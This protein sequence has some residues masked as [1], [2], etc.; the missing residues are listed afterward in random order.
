[1]TVHRT[2]VANGHT[3]VELL[4]TQGTPIPIVNAFLRHLAAR[5][6]SPNTLI[7]YAH[8]LQH[9]WQFQERRI[10]LSVLLHLRSILDS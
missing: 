7:A 8:D 6:Y 5:D 4:D 1:M 10:G 9:L 2:R 3:H